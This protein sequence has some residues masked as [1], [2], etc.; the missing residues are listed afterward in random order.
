MFLL[1]QHA[2]CF[3]SLCWMHLCVPAYIYM[4]MYV[5]MCI[6]T[7]IFAYRKHNSNSSYSEVR[8]QEML[9][10][11]F[12]FSNENH[13]IL[14]DSMHHFVLVRSLDAILQLCEHNYCT[15]LSFIFVRFVSSF[16]HCWSKST[17]ILPEGMSFATEFHSFLP[18]SWRMNTFF[19]SII[20]TACWDLSSRELPGE[21]RVINH[22]FSSSAQ[23]WK[24]LRQI[25]AVG[26]FHV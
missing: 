7:C 9:N 14:K 20:K 11:Y 26:A 2:P 8:L 17:L 5:C 22:I 15:N 18:L 1:P 21:H 16:Q 23:I 19:W 13:G 25:K 12:S 10:A 3:A 24:I 6:W 4:Y